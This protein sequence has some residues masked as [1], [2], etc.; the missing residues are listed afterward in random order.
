MV[1]DLKLKHPLQRLIKCRTLLILTTNTCMPYLH[2]TAVLW[3][4]SQPTE[5]HLPQRVEWIIADVW[6][7]IQPLLQCSWKVSPCG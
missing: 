3:T 4:F 6:D 7:G 1:G 5:V 2:Q